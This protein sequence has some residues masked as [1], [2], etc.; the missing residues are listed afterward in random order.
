MTN[1]NTNWGLLAALP[2]GAMAETTVTVTKFHHS[3]PYSGRAT[4]NL[5]Y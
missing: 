4:E 2:T 3:Y 5:P 1:A